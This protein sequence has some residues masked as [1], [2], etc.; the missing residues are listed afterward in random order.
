MRFRNFI[1][2]GM[3]SVSAG[4]HAEEKKKSAHQHDAKHA[5]KV[6]MIGDVHFEVTGDASM[7]M[8]YYFDKFG[9]ALPTNKIKVDLEL[10]D[11]A[12]RT[13]L[14][15]NKD[16]KAPNLIH[17]SLPSDI[18]KKVAEVIIKAKNVDMPKGQVVGGTIAKVAIKDLGQA[19]VDPHAEHKM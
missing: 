3:L 18:D 6:L 7:L 13:A 10:V 15:Y 19:V 14:N 8:I 1:I 11:G 9:E 12:K 2:L 4:L 16:K 5:G 17:V